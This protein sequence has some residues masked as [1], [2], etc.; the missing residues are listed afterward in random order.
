MTGNLPM[1]MALT[2]KQLS[3]ERH[4]HDLHTKSHT[5]LRTVSPSGSNKSAEKH[6]SVPR[7]RDRKAELLDGPLHRCSS[8]P[9]PGRKRSR[10]KICCGT[11]DAHSRLTHQAGSVDLPTYSSAPSSPAASSSTS[12]ASTVSETLTDSQAQSGKPSAAAESTEVDNFSKPRTSDEDTHA[13]L[14]PSRGT[15]GTY[16]VQTRKVHLIYSPRVHCLETNAEIHDT[17]QNK[18]DDTGLTVDMKGPTPELD[19]NRS[20]TGNKSESLFLENTMNGDGLST[21]TQDSSDDTWPQE[22][23]LPHKETVI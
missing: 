10:S 21:F 15:Y 17:L 19:C 2:M 5:T 9:S 8:E 16:D 11:A 6:L 4:D 22:R 23:Q 7:P 18:K 14:T 3:D 20:S 1:A 13:K 12:I